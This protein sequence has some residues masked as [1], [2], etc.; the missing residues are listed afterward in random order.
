MCFNGSI[1][2]MGDLLE[3][4]AILMK[5]QS[6]MYVINIF[7]NFVL[8]YLELSWPFHVGLKGI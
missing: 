6:P 3:I 4:I 5:L 7:L 8:L 1:F 2:K